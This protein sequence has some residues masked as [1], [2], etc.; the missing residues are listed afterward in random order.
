MTSIGDK[1]DDIAV[2]WNARHLDSE[3]GIAPFEK[4][5]SY[6]RSS[7]ALATESLAT[8]TLATEDLPSAS[9]LDI[10]CGSGG[11]FI[12]RL[13]TH[14]FAVTGIDA[15]AKM[16]DLAQDNHPRS[17]FI[18]A[19]IC[20]WE[21]QDSYD[22]ILA[23]DS[24]FHLPLCQQ[25]PVL[26]KLCTWLNK[27]GILFYSFGDDIGEHEGERW[28][29]HDFTYSSIGIAEN[30]SILM[31]AGLCPLHLERDQFPEKHAYIIAMK[32]A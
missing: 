11:R 9:A 26:S 31:A 27:G 4:A 15:S 19:D 13:E 29:G 14:N 30:L 16:I 23:W 25:K 24:L 1:Y 32:S 17:K 20:D 22:F 3:Y 5:L 10:G 18:H 7:E 21:D 6:F 8:E 12:R 2:W 28:R